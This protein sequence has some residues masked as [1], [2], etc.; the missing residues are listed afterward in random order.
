[1]AVKSKPRSGNPLELTHQQLAGAEGLRQ[2]GKLADA[3][4]I[5]QK[6]LHKYP[7]Y[8][9]AL[10][11]LGLIQIE[12][13]NFWGALASFVR[14]A[15]LNPEDWTILTNLCN[16]YLALGAEEMAAHALEQAIELQDD[17]PSIYYSLGQIYEN[18][19]DYEAAAEAFERAL[20]L[21][22]NHNNANHLLAQCLIHMGRLDQAADALHKAHKQDPDSAS[23]LYH[24]GQLPNALV[25]VDVL[26]ALDKI[27]RE[28]RQK[29]D[30][31]ELRAGF[32]GGVALHNLGRY[33]EAWARLKQANDRIDA[34]YKELYAGNQKRTAE[35]LRLAKQRKFKLAKKS[36]G[37]QPLSLFV[38]G[39]TRAGKTTM[40]RLVGALPGVRRGYESRIIEDA[41]NRASQL[42]GLLT[43]DQPLQMPNDLNDRFASIYEEKLRKRAG[44]NKVFTNTHPGRISDVSRL[45]ETIPR[46]RFVFMKRRHDDTVFRILT[47]HYKSKTNTYAYNTAKA[48]K[49]VRWYDEMI[50]IWAEK[51]GDKAIIVRYEDMVED[52][53]REL[54][55]V[56]ELCGLDIAGLEL[57]ETGDDRDCALPYLKYLSEDS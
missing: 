6:L 52:P 41:V 13:K 55:R 42:S 11:T 36:S 32:A 40:E 7:A 23:A 51:L 1:M 30:D 49:H 37:K 16:V 8:V 12:Q 44:E 50:D 57:P 25:K 10:H 48:Y 26:A 27:S 33:D 34:G 38:L 31:F 3:E 43:I 45:A 28:G 47:K 21:D 15:M 19:R 46:I 18:R 56:A 17:E 29:D 5:C 22:S 54:G 14:A 39:V 20:E 2:Q 9:A 24:F 53:A 35:A 4:R